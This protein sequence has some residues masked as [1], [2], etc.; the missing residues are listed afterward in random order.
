MSESLKMLETEEGQLNAV[1]ACFGSAAQ[2][3]QLFE[4]ELRT[5]L[6]VYNQIASTNVGIDDLI[7]AESTSQHLKKTMGTLLNDIRKNVTFSEK[8]INVKL[9]HAIERRNFLIHH[10]FLDRGE[11]FN[12]V[13]GRMELLQELLTIGEELQTARGWIGG[14]RIALLE[15]VGGKRQ[16]DSSSPVV[17]TAEIDLPNEHT[18]N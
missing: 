9:N 16:S 6:S 7:E 11:K 3:S 18:T 12:S 4:S 17:L 2:H 15:T 10:F 5:F 14:L 8:A 13:S 1:F